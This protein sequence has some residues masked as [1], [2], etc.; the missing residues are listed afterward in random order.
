M[1]W[2]L[3]GAALIVYPLFG[4]SILYI[5]NRLGKTNNMN[6]LILA[7]IGLSFILGFGILLFSILSI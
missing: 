2:L 3:I 7:P 4:L 1:N 6:L 5:R